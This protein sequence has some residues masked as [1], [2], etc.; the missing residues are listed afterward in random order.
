MTETE[1]LLAKGYVLFMANGK[2]EVIKPPNFGSVSIDYQE[3][4]PLLKRV[5]ATEKIKK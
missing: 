5:N 1:R 2:I 4:K 3:G